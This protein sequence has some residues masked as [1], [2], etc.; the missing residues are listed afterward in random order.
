MQQAIIHDVG[1]KPQCLLVVLVFVG[2]LHASVALEAHGGSSFVT[3]PATNFT[4]SSVMRRPFVSKKTSRER[5]GFQFPRF[6]ARLH[7]GDQ[8]QMQM[9]DQWLSMDMEYG[10]KVRG[11][12]VAMRNAR[13]GKF[14]AERGIGIECTS[15]TL[16]ES[17]TFEVAD[18][19]NGRVTLKF[20]ALGTFCTDS[21]WDA[22]PHKIP[23]K[24]G[25][26]QD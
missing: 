7:D 14:C 23:I 12:G 2:S 9:H 22:V 13:T 11:R 17:E 20:S 24:V 18:V 3:E 16:K 19:W 25:G 26:I 6:D 21:P 15:E 1:P 8:I 4:I 10:Y 5:P